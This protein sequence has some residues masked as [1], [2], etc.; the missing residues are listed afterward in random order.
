MSDSDS[1][2]LSNDLMAKYSPTLARAMLIQTVAHAL[3]NASHNATH[4]QQQHNI[5]IQSN[6]SLGTSIIQAV[7]AGYAK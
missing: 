7:G 6:T 2:K 1:S 5:I 3:S 4:T